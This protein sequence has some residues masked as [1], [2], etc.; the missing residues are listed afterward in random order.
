MR[1]KKSDKKIELKEKKSR[2]KYK[3]PDEVKLLIDK[4]NLVPF[5]TNVLNLE[6]ELEMRHRLLP[7]QPNI[8]VSQ[9]EVLKDCLK[10]LPEKF[11]NYIKDFCYASHLYKV[12]ID[13]VD[14]HEI[15]RMTMAY[16]EF[17]RLHNETIY[18]ARRLK[19]EKEGITY[20]NSWEV[21]PIRAS[22]IIRKDENGN[23]YVDGLAGVI[24][25]IIPDRFRMCEICNLIFWA[26]YKNSLTCSKPCLNALRQRRHRKTN[27]EA[28]NAK[29]RANY[30]RNKK[31]KQ[32]KDGKNGTL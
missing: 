21:F 25:K 4:V 8:K 12:D 32:I 1:K 16:V 29:R 28:I 14:M 20:P 6:Y 30:K 13:K 22:G 27:K 15:G 10:D 26:N 18:Y 19:N 17:Q 5:P 7:V 2:A 3:C 24:H 31:L 9:R 23:N 11:Q